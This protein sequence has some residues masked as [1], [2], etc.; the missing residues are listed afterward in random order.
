MRVLITG[1]GGQLGAALVRLLQVGRSP[2][3]PIPGDYAGAE[4]ASLG[5]QQLDVADRT[6][7]LKQVEALRPDVIFHCAAMTDVNG[8]ES[9]QEEAFRVN[10]L[11]ARNLA[12]AASQAGARLVHLSTDYVFSGEG[13][14]P[15]GEWEPPNPQSVYGRSKYL[16]EQ[17]VRQFC[18][19]SFLVR[20]AWLYGHSGRNFVKT[21]LR[22]GQQQ[23]V[24]RV[25]SDQRGSPTYAP[26]LAHHLLLLGA[27]EEFGIYHCTGQGEC[28]W[29]EFACAIMAA[30]GLDC[31][32]EP[33][34][35]AQYPTP[36]RRPAYSA[37]EH[38]MLRCTVG[39]GMRPWQQALEEFIQE[40][41]E[42]VP[43]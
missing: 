15:Y 10:A 11:G 6:A 2:L 31:R 7:V 28:S 37:L 34:T 26:E 19:R 13:N 1:G 17:Y 4:V 20:T 12:M 14:T 8:C 39:D 41:K 35:T 16:G 36:A 5:R 43:Q 29:Y 40:W 3:G 27:T 38:Y 18:P 24:V 23:S 21:M 32:V 22:L 25:V 30:A 33:C 42:G 9:R